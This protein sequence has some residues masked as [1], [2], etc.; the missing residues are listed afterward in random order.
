VAA[1]A[2]ATE[3]VL[4]DPVLIRF[5]GIQLGESLLDE[6]TDV[7]EKTVSVVVGDV[8]FAFEET[9]TRNGFSSASTSDDGFSFPETT[10][11][12]DNSHELLVGEGAVDVEFE[13]NG[14]N[15]DFP[16]LRILHVSVH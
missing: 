13:L 1:S 15:G 3:N 2:V 8:I 16:L 5:K 12:D 10:A 14:G 7:A 9:L 4:V 11:S 6:A